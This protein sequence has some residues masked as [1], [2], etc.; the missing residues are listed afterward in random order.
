MSRVDGFGIRCKSLEFNKKHIYT[1]SFNFFKTHIPP[2]F[3]SQPTSKYHNLWRGRGLGGNL[4]REK[5]A[6]IG[7]ENLC[8]IKSNI[9]R[10]RKSDGRLKMI[11]ASN[12][13]L[14][15]PR[16]LF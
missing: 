3:P 1:L 12:S 2:T 4:M 16:F 15:A 9:L 11:Y 13:V 10:S 5:I 8:E 7:R 6:G 14:S